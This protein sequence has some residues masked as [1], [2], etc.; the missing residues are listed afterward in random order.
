MNYPKIRS[1]KARDGHKLIVQFDNDQKKEYDI[2]RLLD[3]DK[4]RFSPL[5]NQAFF[6]A[7]QVERGGYALVWNK[8]IDISEY[9]LWV[10]GKDIF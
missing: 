8:D 3:L 2:H 1:A 6:K 4:E 9:E 10:N 5:K 7:V